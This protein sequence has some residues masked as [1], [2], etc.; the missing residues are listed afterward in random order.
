MLY[1]S[2]LQSLGMQPHCAGV[3][4]HPVRVH[5]CN[6]L[7]NDFSPWLS[8]FSA[9]LGSAFCWAFISFTQTFFLPLKTC[10]TGGGMG[11][12]IHTTLGDDLELQ[13]VIESC[14]A[15]YK[16]LMCAPLCSGTYSLHRV[17]TSPSISW[18]LRLKEC[19]KM[20]IQR[21]TKNI[22]LCW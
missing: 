20:Q 13:L 3:Y 7:S 22:S 10:Y 17:N 6:A 14:T 21:K 5:A 16:T 12:P 9:G 8:L 4:L 18:G 15:V 19:L 1:E 11:L 2:I